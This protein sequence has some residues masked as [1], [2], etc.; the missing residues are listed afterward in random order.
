M[1]EALAVEWASRRREIGMLYFKL[2]TY[3]RME[4]VSL[5]ELTLWKVK[6]DSRKTAYDT[7]HEPDEASTRPKRPRLEKSNLYRADR[8]SC[9]INSCADVVISNVVPFLAK[10]CRDDYYSD[11]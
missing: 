3:E 11:D 9:L 7:G 4:T 1:D 8:Q 6:I 2:A 5:L 10:V